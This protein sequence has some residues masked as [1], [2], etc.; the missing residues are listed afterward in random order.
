MCVY[1][2]VRSRDSAVG[3][4]TGY[5]LDGSGV[6]VPVP[7][8]SRISSYPLCACRSYDR[9][10]FYT[11]DTRA[12]FPG[13]KAAGAWSWPFTSNLCKRKKDM[14]LYIHL[15]RSAYLVNH[16][17]SCVTVCVYLSLRFALFLRKYSALDGTR[18]LITYEYISLLSLCWAKWF[19]F[20]LFH[21]MHW[22][23]N[24]ILFSEIRLAQHCPFFQAGERSPYSS[25]LLF[26]I[27]V[28]ISLSSS[29]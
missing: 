23:P 18:R 26:P 19:Q 13:D 24:L 22:R 3:I 25:I 17:N 4:A 27:H 8:V 21:S 15:W 2:C 7:S 29:C 11:A 16:R 5:E 20:T 28:K 10:A 12:L 14:H 1:M 9:P 6:G